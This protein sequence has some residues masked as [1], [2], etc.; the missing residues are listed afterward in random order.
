MFS[1]KLNNIKFEYKFFVFY[2]FI[3][4][5]N[6]NNGE[7]SSDNEIGFEIRRMCTTKCK[8]VFLYGP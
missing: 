1:W 8:N 3:L 6:Y 4:I 7:K 2:T 5:S